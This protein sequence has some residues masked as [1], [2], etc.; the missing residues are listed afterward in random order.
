MD[1]NVLDSATAAEWTFSL[2]LRGRPVDIGAD[3]LSQ[4]LSVS[5]I[6][7]GS[8]FNI[9][10]LSLNSHQGGLYGTAAGCLLSFMLVD[11]TR[12]S[13]DGPTS[14]LSESSF[15]LL[16]SRTQQRQS[17]WLHHTTGGSPISTILR[18]SKLSGGRSRTVEGHGTRGI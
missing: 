13:L 3:I 2:R 4:G 10:M 12:Y 5:G 18:F 17:S 1:Q 11:D 16:W 8:R 6:A 7:R 15:S 9:R 14:S